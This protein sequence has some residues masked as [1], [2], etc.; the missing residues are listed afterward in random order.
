LC[1]NNFLGIAIDPDFAYILLIMIIIQILIMIIQKIFKINIIFRRT[2]G[3]NQY[4]YERTAK[5]LKKESIDF[6]NVCNN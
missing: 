6:E 5:D 1:P 4:K 3:R 2:I